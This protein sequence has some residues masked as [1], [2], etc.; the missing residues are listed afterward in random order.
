MESILPL[1]VMR[2]LYRYGLPLEPLKQ[3]LR[4]ERTC[5]W[6]YMMFRVRHRVRKRAISKEEGE[7]MTNRLGHYRLQE[8][9]GSGGYADVY[10]AFDFYLGRYVAVKVLKVRVDSNDL[11]DVLRNALC[12]RT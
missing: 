7:N 5:A 9:I 12:Q 10:K 1:V 2:Q 11:Q 6:Q 8:R 4:M 3:S